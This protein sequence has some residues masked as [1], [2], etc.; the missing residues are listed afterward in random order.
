MM[1]ATNQNGNSEFRPAFSVFR[2]GMLRWFIL[3]FFISAGWFTLGVLVGRGT[4]PVEFDINK[5]QAELIRLRQQHID[6]ELKRFLTADG[7]N[8]KTALSFYDKL[9][10]RK[11]S[12]PIPLEAFDPP[13]KKHSTKAASKIE[14]Q[15]RIEPPEVRTPKQPVTQPLAAKAFTNIR[16]KYTIQVASMQDLNAANQMVNKLK[17]ENYPV[18]SVMSKIPGKGIWHRIRVGRFDSKVEAALLIRRLKKDHYYTM[19]LQTD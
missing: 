19:L 18:Y 10:D 1:A 4:A 6:K 8:G 13:A 16:H 14:I 11:A 2:N 9:K 7:K 17:T 3:F 15:D 5:L 12:E